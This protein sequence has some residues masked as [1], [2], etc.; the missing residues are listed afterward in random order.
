MGMA[1]DFHGGKVLIAGAADSDEV[2]RGLGLWDSYYNKPGGRMR[3]LFHERLFCGIS[4]HYRKMGYPDLFPRAKWDLHFGTD[5]PHD[6][7]SRGE[8]AEAFGKFLGRLHDHAGVSDWM[9]K[10][11]EGHIVGYWIDGVAVVNS[12]LEGPMVAFRELFGFEMLSMFSERSVEPELVNLGDTYQ[13]RR[14][15]D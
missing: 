13:G 14:G 2:L 4:P 3:R 9:V 12:H 8:W 7:Q 6:A 10:T 1:S 11:D 15:V 5:S